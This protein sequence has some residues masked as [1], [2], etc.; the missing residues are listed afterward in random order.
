MNTLHGP[1]ITITVTG[2]TGS[3][4]SRVL[5]LIADALRLCLGDGII[6]DSPD[7]ESEKR[8]NPTDYPSWHSP[9]SGTVFTLKEVNQ[10]DHHAEIANPSNTRA[11]QP[12]NTL[13]KTLCGDGIQWAESGS[14]G[15]VIQRVTDS[16][17]T[18]SHTDAGLRCYP[19]TMPA[20]G[21]TPVSIPVSDEDNFLT[22]IEARL[23]QEVGDLADALLRFSSGT[24]RINKEL[25]ETS[26]FGKLITRFL[27][28]GSFQLANA[29]LKNGD[30]PLLLDDGALQLQELGL[31]LND[32]I[33]ELSLD[34]REFLAI[35]LI[36]QHLT[37]SLNGSKT[38]E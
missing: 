8:M 26:Q 28:D 12:K 34:G 37:V 23:T 38:S 6:I 20:D 10:S 35:A 31:S 13:H 16:T 7:M 18:S 1:T 24:Q 5:A 27:S 22:G 21:T 17:S 15:V 14:P 32:F 30:K 29:L 11:A 33:R 3:G 36:K 25:P 9:R 19:G 4:K 2:P